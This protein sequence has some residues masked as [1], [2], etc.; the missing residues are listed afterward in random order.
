[1]SSHVLDKIYLDI[2]FKVSFDDV[3]ST[4]LRYYIGQKVSDFDVEVNEIINVV[5]GELHDS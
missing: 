1:M 3:V 4:H 2:L 5:T